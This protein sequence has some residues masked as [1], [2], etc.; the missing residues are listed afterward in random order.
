MNVEGQKQYKEAI[1]AFKEGLKTDPVNSGL[2]SG[3]AECYVDTNEYD[4][5]IMYSKMALDNAVSKEEKLIATGI[6]AYA[7]SM[8]EDYNS[9]IGYHK[10]LLEED[11]KN[12]DNFFNYI[13]SCYY[14]FWSIWRQRI[15]TR[16]VN[17]VNFFF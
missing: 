5:A 15:N 13:I 7:Y 8:N 4:I 14:F 9:A 12:R 17:Y 16:K 3:L 6:I 2:Y 10:E 1:D 11:S